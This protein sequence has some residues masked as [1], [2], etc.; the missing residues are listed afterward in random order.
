MELPCPSP[1]DFPDPGMKPMSLMSP[2]LAVGFFSTSTIWEAQLVNTRP[3]IL[4]CSIPG[5][6]LLYSPLNSFPHLFTY[7]SLSFSPSLGEDLKAR[8]KTGQQE[9]PSRLRKSSSNHTV[10]QAHHRNYKEQ[11]CWHPNWVPHWVTLFWPGEYKS[12]SDK[13]W[14][15]PYSLHFFVGDKLCRNVA[16]IQRGNFPFLF[17]YYYNKFIFSEA[18]S[19]GKHGEKQKGNL[20][21]QKEHIELLQKKEPSNFEN[22]QKFQFNSK[23]VT[24]VKERSRRREKKKKKKRRDEVGEAGEGKRRETCLSIIP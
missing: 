19:F 7:A 20:F 1:G 23:V 10:H 24:K 17:H 18:L 21:N 22:I 6:L 9:N 3:Q 15:A 8:R 11:G 12:S 14:C 16:K 13:E 4:G 2:A 5:P